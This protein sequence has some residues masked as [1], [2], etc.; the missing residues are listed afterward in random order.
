VSEQIVTLRNR[1]GHALHCMLTRPPAGVAR[2]D[3]A[4]LLLSPGVKM[5]VAPHRLY[6]KLAGQFLARGI[7]VMRV[8]F[9]GL[10]DSEGELPETQLDQLYRQVQLGRHVP[11]VLAA[12]DWLADH[13][14]IGRFLVGG[15]CGGAL[16]GLLAAERD[17]RVIGLYALGMPTV[18]DASGAHAADVMT[19]GQL[20]R[21]R[22]IYLRKIFDVASWRRLLTARSDYRTILRSIG[23]ALG[24]RTRG[25]GGPS[26]V[27]VPAPATPPAAN[28]NHGF[29]RAM[30]QLLGRGSPALMVFSGADRLHWEYEEKFARPWA[31]SLARFSQLLELEMIPN[32]NH[33]ISDPQWLDQARHIT[34]Q[35]LDRRFAA[36]A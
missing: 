25:K 24:L 32:A 10:G 1:A 9:H 17:T 27:E 3:L 8:D 19:Q 20:N 22:G 4:C 29:V 23:G 30:F 26:P 15:L 12:M 2:R 18:L 33:V 7:T 5:R 36:A 11:D 16:T 6:R 13:E 35:W 21:V 34:A 31:A 14:K 28:L